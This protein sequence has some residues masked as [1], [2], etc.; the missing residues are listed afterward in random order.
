M[1]IESIDRVKFRVCA[2]A[3][4]ATPL[5]SPHSSKPAVQISIEDAYR[6]GPST[7]NLVLSLPE[8]VIMA[9]RE[10]AGATILENGCNAPV[11][12]QCNDGCQEDLILK[13]EKRGSK[14]RKLAES[15]DI[16]GANRNIKVSK[17]PSR[18]L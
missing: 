8:R 1:D 3:T 5:C 11:R 15:G 9:K 14:R 18:A 2:P 16:E 17:V 6:C 13:Y 12:K 4:L 10:K 7:D